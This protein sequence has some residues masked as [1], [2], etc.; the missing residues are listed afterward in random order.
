MNEAALDLPRVFGGPAGQGRLK[1]EPEDFQVDEILG[2]EPQGQGDFLWLRWRKRNTNTAWL[3]RQLAEYAGLPEA[4]VSY[5]GLKD[6]HA[7]TTQWF[8]LALPEQGEPDWGQLQIPNCE[9][10]DASRHAKPLRRGD[11]AANAFVIRIRDFAGDLEACGRIFA[12]IRQQGFPNWFGE[13][14]FGHEGGNLEAARAWFAGETRP[15]RSEQGFLLSAVRGLVFNQVLLAR[16]EAGC[17]D[18]PLAG[19]LMEATADGHCFALPRLDEA[20]VQQC[21]S[22]ECT[23]TGPLYG[24]GEPRPRAEAFRLEQQALAQSAFWCYG[25]KRQRMRAA[26]R[27]LRALMQQGHWQQEANDLILSFQLGTGSYATALLYELLGC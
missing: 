19:D 2:F 17:W 6:R 9:L 22:L 24:D 13:Q 16:I 23:P 18:R 3:A 12:R 5:A 4:Q 21:Q 15:K 20:I 27:P 26:R 8:S 11:H 14:R 10:L 25:L 7:V 1:A